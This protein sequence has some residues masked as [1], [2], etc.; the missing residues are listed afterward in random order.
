ML[1]YLLCVHCATV[2]AEKIFSTVPIIILIENKET[3]LRDITLTNY[4][5]IFEC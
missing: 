2:F 3:I 5:N 4:G 1:N